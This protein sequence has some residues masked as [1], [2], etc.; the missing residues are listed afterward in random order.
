MILEKTRSGLLTK[1]TNAKIGNARTLSC[2]PKR[3]R[4]GVLIVGNERA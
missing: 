1:T 2:A 4:L 3:L